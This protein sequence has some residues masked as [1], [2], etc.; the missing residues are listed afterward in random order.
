MAKTSSSNDNENDN[1]DENDD[2]E[3]NDALLHDKGIMILKALSKNKNACDNLY[4]IMSALVERGETIEALEASLEE[5]GKIERDDAMEK[6]SLEDGL[7]LL[8]RKSKR[9]GLLLRR[10]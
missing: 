6:T 3:N 2:E 9:L 7:G 8:L 5:K 10:N 4:E 1:N